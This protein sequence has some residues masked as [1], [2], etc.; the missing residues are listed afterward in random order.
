MPR[1]SEAKLR[2]C[3]VARLFVSG[4]FA[5]NAM[6]V[7]SR[8]SCPVRRR[9]SCQFLTRAAVVS[10]RFVGTTARSQ[11]GGTLRLFLLGILAIIFGNLIMI[12]AQAEEDA[13]K[14]GQK[15]LSLLDDQKYEES[16]HQASSMFR[17]EVTQE[18]WFAALKR[19]REPLGP[20][21][22]RMPSRVQFSRFLRGAPEG[23]YAIIHFTTSF[24][25]KSATER[26]TL[27][28]EDGRWQMAA[29]GI[30]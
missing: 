10:T 29:Y 11:K 8:Y 18:Q 6:M 23:D 30:Y 5:H 3:C 1:W 14:A 24:G 21:V 15:W 17:S 22:S 26:L 9:P 27:V 2:W 20:V 12:G 4:R 7:A 16:W 25:S 28:K 19:F 13:A